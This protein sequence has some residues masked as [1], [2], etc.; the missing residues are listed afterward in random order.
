VWTQH[1]TWILDSTR[2]KV[3]SREMCGF[4]GWMVALA[5]SLVARGASASLPEEIGLEAR[6]AP[7]GVEPGAMLAILEAEMAPVRVHF[8]DPDV[9]G[10][11]PKTILIVDGCV[12]TAPSLSL[13]VSREGA[14]DTVNVDLAA[15]SPEARARTVALLGAEAVR[16]PPPEPSTVPADPT[17]SEAARDVA[18]LP[19]PV[20]RP[21][22]ERAPPLEPLPLSARTPATVVG[23]GGAT[24]RFVPASA[25]IFPGVTGGGEWKPLNVGFLAVGTDRASPTGR[26]RVVVVAATASA[27][28]AIQHDEMGV[29]LDTEIGAAFASGDPS[30]ALHLA[31]MGNLWGRFPISNALSLE[32]STG[33]GYAWSHVGQTT[34]A[35]IGLDGWFAGLSVAV[36]R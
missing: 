3:S 27:D 32:T 14:I 33:F 5:M 1:G 7:P 28:A 12:E 30:R 8:L 13:M 23:R 2:V 16:S 36:R 21:R 9:A 29:R 22:S 20:S 17:E 35:A 24:V 19:R 18:T 31:L 34:A 15:T 10:L 26:H 11:Q 6:C 25:S 4:R